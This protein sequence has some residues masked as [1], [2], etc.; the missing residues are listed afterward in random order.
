[1]EGFVFPEALLHIEQNGGSRTRQYKTIVVLFITIFPQ[2]H[3]SKSETA[4]RIT[5]ERPNRP[6]ERWIAYAMAPF[7]VPQTS[8]FF[9]KNIFVLTTITFC[10]ENI[11][12]H[13]EHSRHQNCPRTPKPKKQVSFA[14][15]ILDYSF[16]LDNIA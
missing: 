1:M 4:T 13:R 8:L 15:I 11:A 5:Q 14:T 7:F 9:L 16:S 10:L 2:N 3:R 12:Q 6:T